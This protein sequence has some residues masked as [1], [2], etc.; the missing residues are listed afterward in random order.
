MIFILFTNETR[1]RYNRITKEIETA[2]WSYFWGKG[3]LNTQTP[4]PLGTTAPVIDKIDGLFIIL[5]SLVVILTLKLN[6]IINKNYT[7]PIQG[8]IL[9]CYHIL[10][11]Q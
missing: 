3:R 4:P 11:D 5:L 6:D 7:K 8:S 9:I 2:D 10:Y 1:G